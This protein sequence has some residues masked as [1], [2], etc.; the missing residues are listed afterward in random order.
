LV[1]RFEKNFLKLLII[2]GLISIPFSIQGKNYKNWLMVFL[3]NGYCNSFV[4]PILAK[5]NYLQYPVRILPKF[6]KSSIIYDYCLCSLVSVWY[7]RSTKNDN[8]I[9]AF[10]KVWLFSLPQAIVEKW[11][12]KHTQLIKYKKGWTWVHSLVTIST[13]K[14]VIRSILFLTNWLDKKI[15]LQN[16]S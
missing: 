9:K 15:N 14:L 12:E 3:F 16:R 7:C 6:Y 13:A 4:A 1:I 8:W 10:F 2:F 11:L 5:K